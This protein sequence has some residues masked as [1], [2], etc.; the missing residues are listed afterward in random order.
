[1]P[2]KN[3]RRRA[4]AIRYDADEDRAP[5]VLAKGENLVADRIVEIA[6]EADIPIVEDAALVSALLVLEL[7]EE[8]PPE[9][10]RSVAKILSFL[11]TLDKKGRPSPNRRK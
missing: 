2:D 11:Y 1:M 4:A 5:K 8:I 9:L 10:Y 7:G 6:K 3:E